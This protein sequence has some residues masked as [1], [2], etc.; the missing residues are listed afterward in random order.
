LGLYIQNIWEIPWEF[1]GTAL[2]LVWDRPKYQNSLS[3][4]FKTFFYFFLF[5]F[6]KTFTTHS[7]TQHRK[8]RGSYPAPT[9][10]PPRGLSA[11]SHRSNLARRGHH[12]A[13]SPPLSVTCPPA[14]ARVGGGRQSVAFQCRAAFHYITSK[15]PV[16]L[17]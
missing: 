17:S 15:Y 4:T 14:A 2:G 3:H 8:C 11:C 1:L 13:S 10:Q 12:Y 6:I 9:P 16:K 5:F 7:L